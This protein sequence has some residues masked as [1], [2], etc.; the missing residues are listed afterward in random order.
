MNQNHFVLIITIL[1]LVI[2]ILSILVISVTTAS[3]SLI[4]P[5]Y[6]SMRNRN[7]YWSYDF[8]PDL[9]E[10]RR[11]PN[12]EDYNPEDCLLFLDLHHRLYRKEES[13]PTTMTHI[14][15]FNRGSF[16]RF[17]VWKSN[18]QSQY[19]I[20]FGGVAPKSKDDLRCTYYNMIHPYADTPDVA[21]HQGF[22]QTFE[23][24]YRI[25]L[26]QCIEQYPDIL[27]SRNTLYLVG[28]SL[29]SVQAQFAAIH[30]KKRGARDIRLFTFS[31]SRLGNQ[32][33]A[34]RVNRACTESFTILNTEDMFCN[35]PMAVMPHYRHQRK[36]LNYYHAGR[37]I[38]W[39]SMNE[40][41]I[42][43]NHSSKTYIKLMRNQLE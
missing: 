15:Q 19:Y 25:V 17:R 34:E 40:G 38:I 14:G 13:V 42:C 22:Y 16:L 24:D 31:S 9:K 23:F 12:P 27:S 3:C 8:V 43:A 33:M 39:L 29:G 21:V 10:P 37:K 30:L 20:V 41:S 7:S 4:S 32:A 28:Q 2:I 18:A 35:L 36:G 5:V 11:S 26:D 6:H 1:V